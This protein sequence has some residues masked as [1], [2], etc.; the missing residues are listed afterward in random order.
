M[1]WE[2]ARILTEVESGHREADRMPHNATHAGP[3]LLIALM[4]TGP[5]LAFPSLELGTPTWV[6]FAVLLLHARG[7]PSAMAKRADS[8][9][10]YL[11]SNPSPFSH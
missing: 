9:S 4:N 8:E 10:E 2:I 7:W 1:G 5:R 3:W 11:G 6:L